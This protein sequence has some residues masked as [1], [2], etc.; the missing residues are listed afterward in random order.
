[1]S[2][3]VNRAISLS[4]QDTQTDISAL[5]R[6]VINKCKLIH[7]SKIAE[8]EQL[9]YYL[10]NRYANQYY[11]LIIKHEIFM[12]KNLQKRKG[13][14]EARGCRLYR[15]QDQLC[16]PPQV[17]RLNYIRISIGNSSDDIFIK[18]YT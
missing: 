4:F 10:Q 3:Q 7:P 1:M 8:V 9:L 14:A 16:R 6:E 5:A 11:I 13:P 15:V 18:Q 12:G 17:R 2:P